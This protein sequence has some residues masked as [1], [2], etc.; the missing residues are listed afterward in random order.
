MDQMQRL[1]LAGFLASGIAHDMANPLTAVRLTLD[2][3]AR[4]LDE[5]GDASLD[6]ARAAVA[7]LEELNGHVTRLAEDLRAVAHGLPASSPASCDVRAAVTDAVRFTRLMTAGRARVSV[8]LPP[9]AS[10]RIRHHDLVRVLVNLLVNAAQAFPGTRRDGA[11]SLDVVAS[12]TWVVIDVVD[13]AGGVPDDIRDRLFSPFVSGKGSSGLGLAAGRTML[14]QAGG[15]LELVRSTPQ[16]T[17]F[18]ITV[19][20]VPSPSA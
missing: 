3:L 16:E 17:R 15:Q 18:R 11:V 7:E 2:G 5:R 20:A 12:G 4:Q 19:P 6:E 8:Q 1:E 14:R 10:A 13:D 9:A